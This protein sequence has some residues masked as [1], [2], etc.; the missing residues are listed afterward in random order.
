MKI[1]VFGAQGQLGHE[2]GLQ[3]ASRWPE[4]ELFL[5]GR[6]ECDVT[7]F[8]QVAKVFAE[9]QPDLVLNGTAYNAVD[10]AE[11][12]PEE[13]FRLNAMV[14]AHLAL[15]S[16]LCGATFVHYSTDYVFGEG[17]TSPISEM[18]VASPN[19]VY[20]KS[21]RLGEELVLQNNPGNSFVIRCCG[22]YGERRAN[23]VRTMI[24]CALQGRKLTVVEDQFISPTWVRPLATVTLDLLTSD[25]APYGIYHAVTQGQ[26]SWYEYADTIFK[27]L[28]LDADLSPV[29]Q[30]DWGAKAP[31]P[32]YSVLDNMQLRVL[33]LD[34]MPDWKD[35]L[36]DFLTQYGEQIVS[37]EK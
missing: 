27:S 6:A 8:D 3:S 18:E 4:A 34:T 33:G 37:E 15:N 30:A 31:R 5:L 9:V 28:N 1:V 7:D 21:K 11:D 23:F 19:S 2:L 26:C 24:R 13:A 32:S 25:H 22:L 14:P 10:L 36:E 20:G 17:F 35:S 12:E 16:A 29:L